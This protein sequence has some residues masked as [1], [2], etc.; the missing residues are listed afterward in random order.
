MYQPSDLSFPPHPARKPF[1]VCVELVLSALC[2]D[3]LDRGGSGGGGG[4]N[5]GP[6]TGCQTSGDVTVYVDGSPVASISDVSY[7][8]RGCALISPFSGMVPRH[9]QVF[10]I[11]AEMQV[12]KFPPPPT[13]A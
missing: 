8:D 4:D 2:I 12:T 11:T 9:G 13:P 10:A 7:T 5:A 3:S 1:L 6:Q